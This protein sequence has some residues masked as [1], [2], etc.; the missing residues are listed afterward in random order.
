MNGSMSDKL[1]L[2]GASTAILIFVLCILIF[3]FRLAGQKSV[4]Y[5]LGVAFLVTAVPLAYLLVTAG[6]FDRPALYYIQLGLMITFILVEF[7]L[8]YLL[9][10]D[11][12]HTSWITIVYVTLFFAST[13]GMIGVASLAGKTWS[14]LTVVLFLITAILAFYQRAK[15][16]L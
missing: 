8:D 15:T 11:F 6:R 9:K 12:R 2:L 13:G 16:G 1:N 4:E 3:I 10:A 5:G 14:I 7:L